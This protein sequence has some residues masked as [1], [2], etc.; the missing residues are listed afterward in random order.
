MVAGLTMLVGI[1]G[2]VAQSDI[3]RIF[4]FTLVSHIGYMIFGVALSTAPGWPAAIFYVVHHI[5][6][7]TP[8]SWSPAWS[9]SGPAA[10]TCAGSA[11]WPG[12]PR[13]SRCSSSSPR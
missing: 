12:S 8:S 9:R 10:P 5:T 1:L 4:S 3:K 6:I 11:A 7:Q 13:C 2:A